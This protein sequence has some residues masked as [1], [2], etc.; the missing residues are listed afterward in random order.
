MEATGSRRREQSR[1]WMVTINNPTDDDYARLHSF[2]PQCTYLV[3][4]DEIGESGTPHIQSFLILKGN[5]SRS[6]VSTLFPRAN[7]KVARGTSLQ[8]SDYCKKDNTNVVEYGSLPGVPG[9]NGL[10]ERFREWVL[11]QPTKPTGTMVAMEFP[12]LFLRNSRTQSFIDAIYPAPPLVDD[13]PL[14][15]YQQSLSDSLD[16]PADPRKIIFVVDIHGNSGKSWFANRYFRSNPTGVQILSVGKRDDLAFAVDEHKH[17]FLFD[18]PRSTSEFLQYSVLEQLK[19]GLI[20]SNKYES[21]M[22][23][24]AAQFVHVVVFM[25]EYPDFTKLS[26]DRYVVLTWNHN[27]PEH[28]FEDQFPIT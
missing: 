8:A 26:Q 24:M 5:K 28:N 13:A 11:E 2:G 6:G 3:F 19:N 1:R 18:L 25:N 15:D 7:L 14:R 9:N 22:K 10:Y 21:R 20:F 16:G 17:V 27:T 23:V 12:S 4:A